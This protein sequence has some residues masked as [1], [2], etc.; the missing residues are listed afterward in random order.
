MTGGH[1][2]S[3]PRRIRIQSFMVA[4][5]FLAIALWAGPILVPEFV[6]R[7]I[8]CQRLAA[9]YRREATAYAGRANT[10][11][12]SGDLQTSG[13]REF[14]NHSALPQEGGRRRA[15]GTDLSAR[16]FYSVGNLV[17]R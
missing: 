16:P 7:W 3:G 2:A 13:S 6:R 8:N 4:V 11:R 10:T 17:S 1:A 15:E 12:V 14:K 9:D 5:V